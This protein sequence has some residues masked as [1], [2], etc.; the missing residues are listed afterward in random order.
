MKCSTRKPFAAL[1]A[2]IAMSAAVVFMADGLI[3]QQAGAARRTVRRPAANFNVRIN[4]DAKSVTAGQT[5]VYNVNVSRSTGLSGTVV[6]DLPNLTERFTGRIIAETSSQVRLEITVPPIANTNS[7]VFILRGR[8]G[9]LT[10]QALFRLNVEALPIATVPPTTLPPPSASTTIAPQFTIA[11]SVLL[12]T[13]PPA[14]TFQYGINVNRSAGFVGPVDLR[15]DGLP[16]GATANFSPNPTTA[17]SVLYVTT[18]PNTPSGTYILSVVATAGSTQRFAAVQLSVVR[19]G[20]FSLALAPNSVSAPA[21]ND[22]VTAVNVFALIG[23]KPIIV[24]PAGTVLT[25]PD[26][27]FL[28]VGLPQGST[29][30]FDP[31]PSNGL[32]SL[33]I[34]TSATTPA[35]SYNLRVIGASGSFNHSVTLRMQVLSLTKSP[36]G[37]F[38]LI[39]APSVASVNPG[40]A[41][42]FSVTIVPNGGFNSPIDFTARNLPPFATATFV[43]GPGNS[44]LMQVLT[45]PTTPS[46]TWPVLITGTSGPL[47]AT[48]Q[49]SLVVT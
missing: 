27:T 10:R 36:V 1:A 6:F 49:V 8:R 9:N 30:V 13:G 47:S 34:R 39:G 21:G 3:G 24:P 12:Q 4:G 19:V 5:A 41:T 35:G 20:D 31:N 15:V 43:R 28:A 38:G 32:T 16:S 46:G 26:V 37:G 18:G 44:V 42:N 11:P 7:G 45:S 22:I 2:I 25:A 40:M 29:A 33:R 48:I 23:Q 17:G 14:R